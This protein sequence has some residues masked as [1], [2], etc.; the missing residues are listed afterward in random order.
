MNPLASHA[1]G[2]L[3]L[4][5][6]R[7]SPQ[8][9]QAGFAPHGPRRGFTRR[10]LTRRAMPQRDSRPRTVTLAAVGYSRRTALGRREVND[11]LVHDGLANARDQVVAS[12][13]VE[14]N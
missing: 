4:R 10:A 5:A 2:R 12:P 1:P 11:E 6:H 9:A 3:A 8:P 7:R 13:G 14:A